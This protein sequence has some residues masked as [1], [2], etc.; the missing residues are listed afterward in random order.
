MKQGRP[1]PRPCLKTEIF[2]PPPSKSKVGNRLLI[3]P[4]RIEDGGRVKGGLGLVAEDDAALADGPHGGLIVVRCPS[5]APPEALRAFP[6]K[7]DD[8]SG[9]AKPVPRRPLA[10]ERVGFVGLGRLRWLPVLH[11]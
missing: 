10:W 6:L 4:Q 3:R 2:F 8:A 7:G 5:E 1:K 9:L 11:F